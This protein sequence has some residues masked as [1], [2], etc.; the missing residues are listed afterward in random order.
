MQCYLHLTTSLCSNNTD[1]FWGVS[2]TFDISETFSDES[3]QLKNIRVLI[4][5]IEVILHHNAKK[6]VHTHLCVAKLQQNAIPM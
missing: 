2:T 3:I 1:I 4:V 5:K 6:I